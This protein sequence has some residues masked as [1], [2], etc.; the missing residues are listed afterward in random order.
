M[1]SAGTEKDPKTA[2]YL[3]L[4]IPGAGQWY[5]DDPTINTSTRGTR[6]FALT[7]GAWALAFVGVSTYGEE[8]DN[9]KYLFSIDPGGMDSTIYDE[10]AKRHKNAEE[11]REEADLSRS[12]I[13]FFSALAVV[14]HVYSAVNARQL[15]KEY[16]ARRNRVSFLVN[17]RKRDVRLVYHYT[18]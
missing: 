13:T 6:H 18:F 3:S 11:W 17:P 9:A 2:F 1:I 8:N 4:F 16:T 5:I 12:M 15:A 10:T 14:S 7:A